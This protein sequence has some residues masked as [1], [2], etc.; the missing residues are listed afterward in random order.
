MTKLVIACTAVALPL[1]ASMVPLTAAAQSDDTAYCRA[2]SSTVRN[3]IPKTQSPTV[4]IPV[5]IA[6]CEAGDSAA[7]I[8]VL[9]HALRDA[10]VTLPRRS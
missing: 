7:A 2:L 3:T 4:S 8:P 5:A 1:A 10:Q 9:E 6:K